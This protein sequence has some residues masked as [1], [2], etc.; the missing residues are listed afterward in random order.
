MSTKPHIRW[1]PKG[2]RIEARPEWNGAISRGWYVPYPN[3][4]MAALRWQPL[5]AHRTVRGLSASWFLGIL[6][7]A[8]PPQ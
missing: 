5:K 3:K 2:K 4:A 6:A 8:P 7:K 1:V